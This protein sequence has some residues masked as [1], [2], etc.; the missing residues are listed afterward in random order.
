M[1]A[2]I[3]LEIKKHFAKNSH[4]KYSAGFW[5]V[6]ESGVK[7]HEWTNIYVDL[8]NL[9][10]AHLGDQLFFISSLERC[11]ARRI[12]FLIDDSL[13]GVYNYFNL[14]YCSKVSDIIDGVDESDLL[15]TSVKSYVSPLD[16]I[17]TSFSNIIIYDL[18]DD[19]ISQPLY[20]HIYSVLIGEN[21]AHEGSGKNIDCPERV[22]TQIT[23]HNENNDFYILND[24]LYSRRF[25][26]PFLYKALMRQLEKIKQQG[27]EIVYVGSKRDA[28]ETSHLLSYVDTDLRGKLKIEELFELIRSDACHGYVGYDNAIMHL[29]LIF[30]KKVYVK[31]RGRFLKKNRDLH[32]RAINCAVNKN[33]ERN[34]QYL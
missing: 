13:V 18:T 22:K 8:R 24:F 26:R 4:H 33:A 15:V 16:S 34:I 5:Q 6:T 30:E 19:T 3:I 28:A 1:I 7:Q 29:F 23:S 21:E 14:S 27:Y 32:Y 11:Q 25:L 20:K 17:I 2:R 9:N 12:L 10:H 31:F